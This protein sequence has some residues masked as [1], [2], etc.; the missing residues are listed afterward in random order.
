MHGLS[1]VRLVKEGDEWPHV[2]MDIERNKGGLAPGDKAMPSTSARTPGGLSNK[3]VHGRVVSFFVQIGRQMLAPPPHFR[4]FPWKLDGSRPVG[5][6]G[7]R[8]STV[9]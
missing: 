4:S 7:W 5:E 1:R 2:R 9:R 3:T 6:V 8:I